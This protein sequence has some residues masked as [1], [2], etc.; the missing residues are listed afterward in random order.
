MDAADLVMVND[1]GHELRWVEM[2]IEFTVD[3][4]NEA[5]LDEDGI[6]E[7]AERAAEAWSGAGGSDLDLV[8]AGRHAQRGLLHDG[9]SEIAFVSDWTDDPAL[10]AV[11]QTW[12]TEDGEIVEFD[13]ALNVEGHAWSLEGAPRRSDLWNTLS[14]ELG[15]AIGLGHDPV[16]AASTMFTSAEAGE[17]EKRDLAASDHAVAAYLY[18]GEDEA[19]SS[20]PDAGCEAPGDEGGSFPASAGLAFVSICAGRR[21]VGG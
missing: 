7:A 10:L 8:Y 17:T 15:H 21:R 20:Q 6:V 12:F 18:G 2:P 14:H 19:I 1:S 9:H 11:T 3:P 13:I 16:E 5:G 4:A